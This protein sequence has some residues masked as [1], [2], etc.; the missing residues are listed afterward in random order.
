VLGDA[1]SAVESSVKNTIS[2]DDEFVTKSRNV[3]AGLFRDRCDEMERMNAVKVW[4]AAEG[5]DSSVGSI[6]EYH[7]LL[8]C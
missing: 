2:I 6:G 7:H 3:S 8:I 5:N 1:A 4:R